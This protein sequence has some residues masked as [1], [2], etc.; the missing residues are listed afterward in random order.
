MA[1]KL[2]VE[3]CRVGQ[4]DGSSRRS[5]HTGGHGRFLEQFGKNAVP[6]NASDTQ[7]SAINTDPR[8]AAAGDGT[9]GDMRLR[10]VFTAKD[11]EVANGLAWKRGRYPQTIRDHGQIPLSCQFESEDASGRAS[12][13]NQSFTILDQCRRALRDAGFLGRAK[14]D[15][16]CK[17]RFALDQ[18]LRGNRTPM[19]SADQTA[20]RE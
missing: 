14:I 15:P 3:F 18:I 19:G 7:N 10:T 16:P 12:V 20:Q 1:K 4:D 8:R 17:R 6:G 5:H 9:D 11:K 13:D 2:L